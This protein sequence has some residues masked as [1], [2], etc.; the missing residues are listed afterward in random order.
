M[1]WSCHGDDNDDLLSSL[2]FLQERSED[3]YGADRRIELFLRLLERLNG[4]PFFYSLSHLHA[5]RRER[6]HRA[7][8]EVSPVPHLGKTEDCLGDRRAE[9]IASLTT[10]TVP[11]SPS[12][13]S[14]SSLSSAPASSLLSSSSL[15]GNPDPL[16]KRRCSDTCRSSQQQLSSSLMSAD[17]F[18]SDL[19][20]LLANSHIPTKAKTLASSG[21]VP[22]TPEPMS[23]TSL[24]KKTPSLPPADSFVNPSQRRAHSPRK[25]PASYHRQSPSSFSSPFSPP[26][27]I[28]GRSLWQGLQQLR[29]HVQSPAA[30]SHSAAAPA[31]SHE[32][33]IEESKQKKARILPA[34]VREETSDGRR[35]APSPLSGSQ[36]NEPEAVVRREDERSWRKNG[37]AARLPSTET[38]FFFSPKTDESEREKQVE[39]S[40]P[41]ALSLST[42]GTTRKE[43]V[44]QRSLSA[45]HR[46]MAVFGDER[47]KR[48]RSSKGLT[49]ENDGIS[50]E[51]SQE[52]MVPA[53]SLDSLSVEEG[54]ENGRKSVE[55]AMSKRQRRKERRRQAARAIAESL[56]GEKGLQ[57]E[58][59]H[60]CF[61]ESVDG[62]QGEATGK[63]YTRSLGQMKKPPRVSFSLIRVEQPLE[64]EEPFSEDGRILKKEILDRGEEENERDVL[65][66][67]DDREK[68][69]KN[70]VVSDYLQQTTSAPAIHTEEAGEGREDSKCRGVT[71]E[72]KKR[73]KE[74]GRH[75]VVGPVDVRENLS[76]ERFMGGE[77][78][79]SKKEQK[80][81]KKDGED[82]ERKKRVC[83]DEKADHTERRQS[84]EEPLCREHRQR[85]V[86]KKTMKVV[87]ISLK[88]KLTEDDIYSAISPLQFL[89]RRGMS[90]LELTLYYDPRT[91]DKKPNDAWRKTEKEECN[92]D[93]RRGTG[94]R[95]RTPSR[96]VEGN[97]ET[98]CRKNS[99]ASGDDYDD[100]L[101]VQEEEGGALQRLPDRGGGDET[102]KQPMKTLEH[103]DSVDG[104]MG[105]N[106]PT[107]E[108][109][110]LCKVKTQ[111]DGV[112]VLLD[113]GCMDTCRE[114]ECSFLSPPL[115]HE[116][117]P[118]EVSS[119]SSSGLPSDV[120][121][122]LSTSPVF[123]ASREFL[124]LVKETRQ[125][126]LRMGLPK[127]FD[128]HLPLLASVLLC[129]HSHTRGT[130]SK[131]GG[132]N[133]ESFS[134]RFLP[135]RP[136]L[137]HVAHHCVCMKSF[138]KI[139]EAH[140]DDIVADEERQSRMPL[141]HGKTDEDSEEF[142]EEEEEKSPPE[143]KRDRGEGE[144]ETM[145]K[146]KGD[147]DVQRSPCKGKNS[148]ASEV[149]VFSAEATLEQ[150]LKVSAEAVKETPADRDS[151]ARK[152]VEC[153]RAIAEA[154]ETVKKDVWDDHNEERRKAGTLTH[155]EKLGVSRSPEMK[156]EEAR[157]S[158]Y[159]REEDILSLT[160]AGVFQA[161]VLRPVLLSSSAVSLSSS[162]R[163]ALRLH[164]ALELVA[165]LNQSMNLSGRGEKGER[166][167]AMKSTRENKTTKAE[168]ERCDD[169]KGGERKKW[170][171]E[172]ST[173]SEGGASSS[174]EPVLDEGKMEN[175]LSEDAMLTQTDNHPAITTTQGH[176]NDED[177]ETEKDENSQIA[178]HETRRH[179]SRVDRHSSPSVVEKEK[180][181]IQ[182]L[183][184]SS[185]ASSTCS[186][187]SSSHV[188]VASFPVLHAS[189]PFQAPPSSA[190]VRGDC[191]PPCI[192]ITAVEKLNGENAQVSFSS[193]LGKWCV[194]SKNVCLLVSSS[195]S[196]K[197]YRR[198]MKSRDA[199]IDSVN[200]VQP[201]PSGGLA[202]SAGVSSSPCSRARNGEEKSF[203][204]DLEENSTLASAEEERKIKRNN[205]S[206]RESEAESSDHA[207]R[208]L[209]RR[210]GE[211]RAGDEERGEE[212]ET[213]ERQ[214]KTKE[215]NDK[216][217]EEVQDDSEQTDDDDDGDDYDLR[218]KKKEPRY[219]H[220]LK[221]A[222]AWRRLI[223]NLSEYQVG[224]QRQEKLSTSV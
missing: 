110:V 135:S 198:R 218:V 44:D 154:A 197:H 219:Q 216:E 55:V 23:Y 57:A 161:E 115:Y 125:D 223:K 81:E 96:S 177:E 222:R 207:R 172:V 179:L 124:P 162:R 142:K 217:E 85:K 58:V 195:S 68:I 39:M 191:A 25:S 75:S 204:S 112:A 136:D 40:Q 111:E 94:G 148:S 122:Y 89:L 80:E 100:S 178:Y 180:D 119:T 201:S 153:Q 210:K 214:G 164:V 130:L 160:R 4:A 69:E 116:G 104:V 88:Q 61:L 86:Q 184:S 91:K 31:S 41:D 42:V 206:T 182:A 53:G 29:K 141:N 45:E 60:E 143:T 67:E 133:R 37:D 105:E 21:H 56:T 189:L 213:S 15:S 32:N 1:R 205:S 20:P 183:D 13:S 78:R 93:S 127:F 120:R 212:I 95:G 169:S 77:M 109:S 33:I 167:S 185:F 43:E 150:I 114:K 52:N 156:E 101:R 140:G 90:L 98:S 79:P 149:V 196:A 54:A 147:E 155:E 224:P 99:L 62:N 163:L 221:V 215:M 173:E 121:L 3:S 28:V 159:T 49:S 97:G 106:H 192:E 123:R 132:D 7:Q 134:S 34:S 8:R 170:L 186:L 87:D 171:S 38:D 48:E 129:L 137:H 19:S 174:V 152:L 203:E 209:D 113:K 199:C 36:P 208:R 131:E 157:R 168:M 6:R 74:E 35:E 30:P 220:A 65:S 47:E 82:R 165:A 144:Q 14:S 73:K 12:A 46:P 188:N 190:N 194:C 72:G 17:F 11:V 18:S 66:S 63:G 102:T 51:T 16:G 118:F 175:N 84:E 128:L 83:M 181:E 70:T 27:A 10:M 202:A 211:G 59:A 71:E 151:L 108:T 24:G 138:N 117:S 76:R 158:L 50:V 92:E 166:V 146:V 139:D 107:F 200:T 193:T 176:E 5:I 187:S 103:V 64:E 126:L 9:S 22:G 2:A 26:S 145:K